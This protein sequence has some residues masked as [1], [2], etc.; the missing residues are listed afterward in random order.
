[1]AIQLTPTMLVNLAVLLLAATLA[2]YGAVRY[3]WEDRRQVLLAF[4]MLV[5][6]AGL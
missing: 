4:I 1:M 6:A 3:V 5:T 2:G